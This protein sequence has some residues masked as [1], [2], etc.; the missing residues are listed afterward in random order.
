MLEALAQGLIEG[1]LGLSFKATG[2]A[3]RWIAGGCKKKYMLLLDEDTA[4]NG[5]TGFVFF[6]LVI[7]FLIWKL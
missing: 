4:A 1:F 2:T 5:I 6:A 3:I 7:G